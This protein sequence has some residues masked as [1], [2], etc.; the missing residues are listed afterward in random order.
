MSVAFN[1]ITIEQVLQRHADDKIIAQA[2]EPIVNMDAVAA[3]RKVNG[4]VC[5]EI[6]LMMHSIEP[7]LV[8][9]EGRLVWR[10]PIELATPVDGHIGLIGSLDVDARMGNLLVPPNFIAEIEANA[11]SLLKNSQIH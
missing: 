4:Y 7:A 10:V 5:G 6:S 2:G 9:S 8:Y 11:R 3:R 1:P